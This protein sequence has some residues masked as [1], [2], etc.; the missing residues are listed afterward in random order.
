MK[1]KIIKTIAVG[2]CVALGV[3]GA[4]ATVYALTGNLDKDTKE[5]SLT[6]DEK[7]D[8]VNAANNVEKDETVYVIAGADGSVEKVIVSDWIKNEIGADKIA[9]KTELSNVETVKGSASYSMDEDNMKVWDAKGNDVYYQGDISK[10]LPVNLKVSYKLDGKA[11]SAEN[12][13]GKS[14]KVTI[15]FDYENNQYD[16][17][18][19]NGVQT[20]MY[21]PFVML[22]GL[23]MDNDNFSNVEVSNGKMFND[24]NR[25]IVAG[26]ALPGMQENLGIAESKLDVPDYVEITAD[27]KDFSLSTTITVATNEVF[28]EIDTSKINNIDDLKDKVGQINDAMTQLVDGSSTLYNGLATLLDKSDAL[29]DGVNRLADGVSALLD[30]SNTLTAGSEQLKDGLNEIASNN[31]ALNAGAEQVFNTLLA[32]AQEKLGALLGGETL[33]IDN[34]QSVIGGLLT[35]P[36]DAQKAAL[37]QLG[38]NGLEEQ[39]TNN[40]I[41][42]AQFPA[43]KLM[44]AQKLGAGETKEQAFAEI[45]ET[46]QYAQ[47]YAAD[48]ST[49]AAYAPYAQGLQTA[50]QTAQTAEGQAAINALCLSLAQS[51]INTDALTALNS[52]NQFYTGL[53]SYTDGVSQAAAGATNLDAGTKQV[54][55]GIAKLYDGIFTMKDGMPALQEGV[56]ALKDGSMQLSDGLKKF[57]EEGIDKIVDLL[58]GDVSNLIERAKATFNLSKE[59]KSFTQSGEGMDGNVKFVYRTESVE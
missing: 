18:D 40:G 17:V 43:V 37:V 47:M 21:V 8:A 12:L 30:G 25:T 2:L 42:S 14:G 23:V 28:S 44:L 33:T 35:N 13:A 10:D 9:D 6:A 4:G 26:I 1:N 54:A 5:E 48:P 36:T 57:K 55:D 49:Y 34:Y 19:I 58:D 7:A 29:V 59:Y 32:S 46:L 38:N 50:T 27:A 39:L 11:I 56:G 15:R 53:K 3:S 22:T 41:P 52:Y 45:G 31:D 16:Y 20:K 24:G 51:S